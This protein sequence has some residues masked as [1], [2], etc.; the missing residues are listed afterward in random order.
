[1]K[2]TDEQTLDQT[3]TCSQKKHQMAKTHYNT[4]LQKHDNTKKKYNN[5][6]QQ[7]GNTPKHHNDFITQ[8]YTNTTA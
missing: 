8:Q 4:T 6:T 2:G 5:T 7:H 3:V 1:M